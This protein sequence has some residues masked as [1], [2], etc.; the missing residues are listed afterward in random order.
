M[1]KL[2]LLLLLTFG[3]ASCQDFGNMRIIASLPASLHEISGIEK[4]PD[5]DLV[6]AISDSKNEPTVYGYNTKSRD[7]ER[8]IKLTNA[9]NKDWEDLAGD[10]EGNLYVGDFGNNRNARKDLR[11]YSLS[12]DTEVTHVIVTR[13]TLPDQTEFPPKKKERNFDIEAFIYKDGYFYLFSRNRS[14]DF[15]GTVKLYKLPAQEGSFTA[16][17]VSAFKTCGD[18]SDCQVT[19]AALDF[20]TQQ[21]ALLS[22]NKVWLLSEYTGDDF[23][24]GRIEK[25]KLGH[26]SQKESICFKDSQTLYIADEQN[27]IEGGNLYVLSLNK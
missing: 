19:G 26:S 24:S 21:I 13:F 3:V 16:T 18:R 5:N 1:Q 4:I 22:H 14:T 25:V 8:V 11:I 12:S 10:A 7:I 27:G 17:L 15:D 20:E 6:W 2:Y 23:F 9:A